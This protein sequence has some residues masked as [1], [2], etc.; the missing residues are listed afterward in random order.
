MSCTDFYKL[1]FLLKL[2]C[3]K[4]S[5]LGWYPLQGHSK[6]LRNTRSQI[7]TLLAPLYFSSG[8]T[9]VIAYHLVS[10]LPWSWFRSPSMPTHT[11]PSLSPAPYQPLP[12]PPPANPPIPLLWR[13]NSFWLQKPHQRSHPLTNH[14]LA[15]CAQHPPTSFLTGLP[16]SVNVALLMVLAPMTT[17][18]EA[19]SKSHPKKTLSSSCSPKGAQDQPQT[20]I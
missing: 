18:L 9:T 19:P 3:S 13:L 10:C 15:P 16:A 2:H 7:F 5:L 11:P 1:I 17:S 14:P 20:S 8:S 12:L 4:V 6:V